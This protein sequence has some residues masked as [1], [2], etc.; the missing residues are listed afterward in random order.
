MRELMYSAFDGARNPEWSPVCETWADLRWHLLSA[1]V[2]PEGTDKLALPAWSP[3]IFSGERRS[4][5]AA[6]SLDLL[7]LD[8]DD[9]TPIADAVARW[10]R[11]CGLLHTSWSHTPEVPKF[12]VVLPLR[13]PIAAQHWDRAWRWASR[14]SGQGIDPKC[15][16]PSRIY[17]SSAI[18]AAR[19][20]DYYATSWGYERPWLRIPW[21]H[22]PEAVARPA[23]PYRPAPGDYSREQ[24]DG[25]RAR[26]LRFPDKRLGLG[27][28]VGGR[29]R[30]NRVVGV[31]CPGCARRSVWWLIEPE[32]KFSAECNHKN[33]CGWTG[34]L[35]EVAH[36]S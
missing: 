15:K 17:F 2:M 23:A 30:G 9:G 12:R 1:P 4:K 32:R 3:A 28:A 6:I 33:S 11:W 20:D 21:E 19:V 7:V 22:M 14:W 5:A 24:G 34:P 35:V 27:R 8:Y 25:A 13:E 18:P 36:V 31:A 26:L 10:R 16:D 29:T